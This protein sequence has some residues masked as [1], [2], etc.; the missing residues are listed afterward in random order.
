MTTIPAHVQAQADEADRKLK[1]L[2]EQSKKASDDV[3]VEPGDRDTKSPEAKAE[4]TVESLKQ[5]LSELTQQHRTLQGKYES[6]VKALQGDV[7]L[8]T[9]LKGQVRQLTQQNSDLTQVISDMRKQLTD[10]PKTDPKKADIPESVA[11]S[12]SEED[13]EYLEAEGITEMAIDIIARATAKSLPSA[14]SSDLEEIKKEVR[15]DREGRFWTALEAAVPDYRE[16]NEMDAFA[17]WL[18]VTLPY[19]STTRREVLRGAQARLDSDTAIRI[20]KDFAAETGMIEKV[21][22]KP[23]FDP[24]KLLE[25]DGSISN[26]PDPNGSPVQGKIYTRQE[27]RSFYSKTAVELSKSYITPERRAEINR[28]DADI[29]KADAEGRIKN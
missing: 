28:I 12:L 10:E 7:N 15:M 14:A 29:M 21:K 2:S 8:L 23:K 22:P 1:E 18:D 24:E 27:V 3:Q 11:S 6:E 9:N 13:R 5:K 25:P 17:D 19:S 26:Q 4:D 16:T 20:F